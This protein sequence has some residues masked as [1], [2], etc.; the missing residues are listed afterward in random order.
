MNAQDGHETKWVAYEERAAA[1]FASNKEALFDVLDQHG[2]AIVTISFDGY[3][4][5]GQIAS[6]EVDGNTDAI[7]SVRV[8]YREV[9]FDRPEP[10]I[11]EQSLE[12]MLGT[13]VFD[14][15]AETHQYW[16]DNEGAY[17][18]VTFDTANRSIKLDFNELFV[19]STNY[20]HEF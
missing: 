9:L 13:V 19:D 6:V 1:A 18:E 8:P 14:C 16:E 17:G 5:E 20:Q 12:E 3:G 7:P 10:E 11:S 4:D 15:L 2:I